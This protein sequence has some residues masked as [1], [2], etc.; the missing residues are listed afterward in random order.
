MFGVDLRK[1]LC[2]REPVKLRQSNFNVPYSRRQPREKSPKG[3]E[4]LC[5]EKR[6]RRDK[7]KVEVPV[8]SRTID[9]KL[10]LRDSAK[11]SKKRITATLEEFEAFCKKDKHYLKDGRIGDSYQRG[12]EA[13]KDTQF[14]FVEV[15]R[16]QD[17]NMDQLEDVTK[18]FGENV[19]DMEIMETEFVEAEDESKDTK[20][21]LETSD[22][23]KKEYMYIAG[24][25]KRRE[26]TSYSQK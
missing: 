24:E 18:W 3:Q 19:A 20:D 17:D 26:C 25:S 6:R 11:E 22:R 7:V 2:G 21:L 12:Q 5:E 16:I 15:D 14:L 1:L 10:S 9:K 13:F 4:H 23:I 8:D